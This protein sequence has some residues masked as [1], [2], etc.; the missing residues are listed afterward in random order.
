MTEGGLSLAS[1]FE[2]AKDIRSASSA[3]L[4]G[5]ERLRSY[6]YER[7]IQ[8]LRDAIQSACV[9]N[10]EA[11]QRVLQMEVEDTFGVLESYLEDVEKEKAWAYAALLCAVADG[12]VPI[13]K[14]VTLL[15]CIRDLTA[16]DVEAAARI[17][18]E[19]RG[20]TYSSALVPRLQEIEREHSAMVRGLIRW[21]LWDD[22]AV[23]GPSASKPND[24]FETLVTVLS[25]PS[26]PTT[27]SVL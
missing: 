26:K 12:T 6:L 27:T 15:R 20:I 5:Y 17:G 1:A 25:G 21:G 13:S 18:N 11:L 23:L 24:N 7:K 9:D 4:A 10:P 3:A 2:V 22:A 19:L 14:L 8:R 16:A